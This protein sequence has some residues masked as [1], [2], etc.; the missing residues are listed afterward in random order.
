MHLEQ[1]EEERQVELLLLEEGG[2]HRVGVNRGDG[3]GTVALAGGGRRPERRPAVVSVVGHC[4]WRR[5][6]TWCLT[7]LRMVWMW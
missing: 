3:V 1:C 5:R 7:W 2:F 6:G 4:K